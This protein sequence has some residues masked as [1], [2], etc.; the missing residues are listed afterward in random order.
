M[1]LFL[2]YCVAIRNRKNYCVQKNFASFYI[3]KVFPLNPKKFPISIYNDNI[4][5]A[6]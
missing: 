6:V 4:S 3:K 1:K 2:S 5:S